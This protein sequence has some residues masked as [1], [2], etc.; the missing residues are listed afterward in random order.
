MY[1][2]NFVS[3]LLGPPEI[4]F[5]YSQCSDSWRGKFTARHLKVNFFF[6]LS[7]HLVVRISLY[8]LC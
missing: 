7:G 8:I 2:E 3:A 4:L 1:F 6:D 5:I